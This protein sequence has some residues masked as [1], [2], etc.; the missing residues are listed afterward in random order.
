MSTNV[1]T[2]RSGRGIEGKHTGGKNAGVIIGRD[3]RG[4]LHQDEEGIWGV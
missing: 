3:G 2:G 4:T 1:Y